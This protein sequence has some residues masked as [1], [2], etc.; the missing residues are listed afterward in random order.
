MAEIASPRAQLVEA[1][2]QLKQVCDQ[3]DDQGLRFVHFNTL[4]KDPEYREE[5]IERAEAS[6]NPR[7]RALAGRL[8]QIDSRDVLVKKRSSLP[9]PVAARN[10]DVLET[11]YE[12]RRPLGR[13]P[14]WLL[15]VL[16]ALGIVAAA[17][18]YREGFDGLLGDNTALVS[19]S[20]FGEQRW[21]ADSRWEL[22]GIVYVEAGAQLVIEPGTEI[23]GRPGSALVVTRDATV[24]A[25]GT[26]DAPIVFSSARPVGQRRA[27]DWGGLVLLGNAPVNVPDAR[28][29]GV[30]VG[31]TR[32][33]FGGVDERSNCGV[34]EYARI[35]FAGY[36]AYAN[37]ELNGLTL[38]GCGSRTIVRHVQVHR[39]LDDGVEV[40]GGTV[41][42]Q[43]VVITGAGDDSLDWDMGWR[44]RVQ[45]LVVQ[46]YRGVGDNAF[47]GD[48]RQDRHD[49]EPVSEP[50]LYNVTLVSSGS[51][52]RYQRAMTLRRGTGGHFRNILIHG[53]SGEA[54]DLRDAATAARVAEGRLSFEGV[55][56]GRVGAGGSS[57]F[58][59]ESGEQDDDGGFDEGVYF[60]NDAHRVLK[61]DNGGL[62][63]AALHAE[64]PDYAPALGSAAERAAVAPPEGE[65]WDEAARYA[66]AVRPGTSRS[67]LAGWTAF[68]AN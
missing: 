8:R 64:F 18:Y 22:D 9:P 14:G 11:R 30:P 19:G 24:H 67:W 57:Y 36:E 3:Q 10:P 66:G 4:L 48:N 7:I 60:T 62:P 56:F 25:R 49:A 17:V 1:L 52:E 28:I 51:A 63:A 54:V 68:P 35:E 15:P 39:A 61:G 23:V 43:R 34:L 58:A 53:F 50:T 40:F 2:W 42:L 55:V 27:G 59:S 65:F 33:A 41:D 29:E 20:L 6:R 21:S 31:D 5:I 32:A 47:E 12:R 38:G 13:R 26:A 37:N 45:F 16:V 44:G 46:Q